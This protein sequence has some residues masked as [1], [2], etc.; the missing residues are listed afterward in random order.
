MQRRR[1]LGRE[2]HRN[3][4][5]YCFQGHTP[6]QISTQKPRREEFQ[7]R[8][9]ARP[10][11]HTALL[12]KRT[13]KG[14]QFPSEVSLNVFRASFIKVER[15]GTDVFSTR[16]GVCTNINCH[17]IAGKVECPVFIGYRDERS[18]RF[19][20]V[21]DSLNLDMLLTVRDGKTTT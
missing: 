17:T 10:L 16:L 11:Q 13:D 21:W 7:A 4:L 19:L 1:F 3:L 2:L 5:T 18:S 12:G 14:L 15:Y 6:H 20:L 8:V 9:G